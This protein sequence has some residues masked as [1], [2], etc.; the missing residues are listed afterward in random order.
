LR[1]DVDQEG[2]TRERGKS[3]DWTSPE[4][5]YMYIYRGK[6]KPIEC[7]WI[8]S[9]NRVASIDANITNIQKFFFFL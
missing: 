6:E 5:I 1:D 4:N 3:K 2:K 7:D 9:G 8:V